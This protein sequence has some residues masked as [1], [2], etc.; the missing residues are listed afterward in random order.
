MIE[1]N[2]LYFIN[3]DEYE[4]DYNNLFDG[5]KTEEATTNETFYLVFETNKNKKWYFSQIKQRDYFNEDVI[6]NPCQMQNTKKRQQ[7]FII[8]TKKQ[9]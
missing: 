9:K 2:M 8:M 7:N 1:D 5:W 4:A 3:T 6:V